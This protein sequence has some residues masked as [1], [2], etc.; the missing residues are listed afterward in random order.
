MSLDWFVDEGRDHFYYYW[1][2]FNR[3]HGGWRRL[4]CTRNG[5][6]SPLKMISGKEAQVMV[7]PDLEPGRWY[8]SV[9]VGMTKKAAEKPKWGTST[10]VEEGMKI[11]TETF[12]RWT[13]LVEPEPEAIPWT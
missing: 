12:K 6:L 10:T 9:R 5:L 1:E 11:A 3:A 7:Q 4:C 8:W 2:I 13:E